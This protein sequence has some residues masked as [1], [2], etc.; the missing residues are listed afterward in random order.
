VDESSHPIVAGCDGPTANAEHR[1]QQPPHIYIVYH[2][3]PR[4]S[5]ACFAVSPILE[6]MAIETRGPRIHVGNFGG[7]GSV[8]FESQALPHLYTGIFALYVCGNTFGAPFPHWERLL[9]VSG[10]YL[11]CD[12]FRK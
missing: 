11:G 8:T 7:F 5:Y 10:R 12:F 2:V 9:K 6:S 3:P 4:S 1:Q